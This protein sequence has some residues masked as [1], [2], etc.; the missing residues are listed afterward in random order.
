[1]VCRNAIW[2]AGF[3]M[4]LTEKCIFHIM[5]FTMITDF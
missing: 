3:M 5:I 2:T 4:E 1:V